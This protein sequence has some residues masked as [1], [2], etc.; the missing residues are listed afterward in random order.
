MQ[1]Q[2]HR[3]MIHR[4]RRRL[5]SRPDRWLSPGLL[6]QSGTRGY[7]HHMIH[8]DR[9]DRLIRLRPVADDVAETPDGID[10]GFVDIDKD[11]PEGF[12]VAMDI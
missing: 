11:L 8:P 6:Y 1:H 2:P 7:Y 9:R 10:M 3:Y 12:H 4:D 5:R